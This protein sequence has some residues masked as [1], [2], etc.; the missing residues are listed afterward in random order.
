MKGCSK[1]YTPAMDCFEEILDTLTEIYGAPKHI[2]TYGKEKT[3]SFVDKDNSMCDV[4]I[5]MMAKDEEYLYDNV[6]VTMRGPNGT[7]QVCVDVSFWYHGRF[8]DISRHAFHSSVSLK[9]IKV[10]DT[11]Q[12]LFRRAKLRWW[13][14]AV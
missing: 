6:S 2:I 10:I 3:V 11:V 8:V 1:F 14:W 5:I 4:K 13:G 9:D 7:Y 12:E